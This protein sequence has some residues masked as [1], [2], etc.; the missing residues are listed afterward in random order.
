LDWKARR[1]AA[2]LVAVTA[3]LFSATQVVAQFHSYSF[4]TDNGSY[5]GGHYYSG[6]S[7]QRYDTD[8]TTTANLDCTIDTSAPVVYYPEWVAIGSSA[9]WVELGTAQ[10]NCET[11]RQIKWWYAWVS[12]GTSSQ[13]IWTQ[14]INGNY[15][16]RFFL[17]NGP[18]S[19]D[20]SCSHGQGGCWEWWIDQTEVKNYFWPNVGTLAQVGF[21]S[22][23]SGAAAPVTTYSGLVKEVNWSTWQ[24]WVP[25]SYT[26][27][28]RCPNSPP[29]SLWCVDVGVSG[30]Y[31]D[32]SDGWSS[33]P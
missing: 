30:N 3:G 15:Q 17:F 27:S 24:S 26:D 6:V 4:G 9:T 1:L 12:N 28:Q 7:V 5:G 14:Q 22:W 19:Q 16:H 21:E 23:D 29:G 31:S 20:P 11:G 10:K 25:G 13:F 33:Q 32:N 2:L 8:A 18:G